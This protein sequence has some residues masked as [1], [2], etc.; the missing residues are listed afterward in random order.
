MLQVWML[1]G[2]IVTSITVEKLE[3]LFD[4]RGLKLHLNQVHGVASQQ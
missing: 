3:E 1:S 4:V 2:E